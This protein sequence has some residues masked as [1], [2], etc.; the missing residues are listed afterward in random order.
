MRLRTRC[1]SGATTRAKIAA[2]SDVAARRSPGADWLVL[3]RAGPGASRGRRDAA[4][5]GACAPPAPRTPG[6]RHG[7]SGKTSSTF[8]GRVSL[9]L[10]LA[11]NLFFLFNLGNP[12]FSWFFTAKSWFHVFFQI[13]IL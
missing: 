10:R 11:G 9:I 4:E 12:D 1:N 2:G 8:I 3:A 5:K 6:H 13:L 7:L